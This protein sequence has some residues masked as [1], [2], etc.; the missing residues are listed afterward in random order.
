MADP[1]AGSGQA[2]KEE[3][4]K[5]ILE[6]TAEYHAV[7]HAKAPFQAGKGRVPY[8]GRVFGA[9]ELQA[10]VGASLDFWLTWGP[11]G[12]A[13]EA[14]LAKLVGVKWAL[15]VNSGSS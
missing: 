5:Q 9:E 1:S 10:A 4:R 11:E 15:G 13:F 7:A 14:E 12:T 6:L 8:A 3:L 2:R